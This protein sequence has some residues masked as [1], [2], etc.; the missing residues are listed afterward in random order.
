MKDS[1]QDKTCAHP[2]CNCPATA[3]DYCSEQC[4]NASAGQTDCKCG[5]QDC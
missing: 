2:P 5:H 4:R 1:A 3:G